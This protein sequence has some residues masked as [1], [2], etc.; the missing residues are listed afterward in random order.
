MTNVLLHRSRAFKRLAGSN[1]DILTFDGDTDYGVVR[2]TLEARGDLDPGIQIRNMWEEL[3]AASDSALGKKLFQVRHRNKHFAPLG[4]G[5]G[6][7]SLKRTRLADDGETVRQVDYF[8][9]D[10]SLLV[11]DRRDVPGKHKRNVTL[12]DHAGKPLH[13]WTRVS[14]LYYFWLDKVIG[15]DVAYLTIDSKTVA[16]F[17]YQYRRDNAATI[18]LLHNSHLTA[19]EPAPYGRLTASRLAG[20]QHLDEF[21]AVA[22]LTSAQHRDLTGLLGDGGNLHVI[23]NSRSLPDVEESDGGRE[24]TKGVVVARLSSTKRLNH[25]I[26]VIANLEQD[27]RLDIYGSGS[28][29]ASLQ[30]LINKL[31]VQ[32]SVKL[33]GH[34]DG[35]AEAF[36]SASFTM[37]TSKFEG[38]GLTLVEAMAVGCIP[39]AYDVKYGPSDIIEDGVSGFV[40]D[41]G[42]AAAMTEALKSFLAKPEHEVAAMREAARRRARLFADDEVVRRWGGMFTQLEGQKQ[43]VRGFDVRIKSADIRSTANGELVVEVE[44]ASSRSLEAPIAHICFLGRASDVAIRELTEAEPVSSGRTAATYKAVIAAEKYQWPE[45]GILDLFL[46]IRDSSGFART[47]ITASKSNTGKQLAENVSSYATKYGNLSLRFRA[48]AD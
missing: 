9:A 28:R 14:D 17:M 15:D 1:V 8:R 31:G 45:T 39:F 47:R 36:Q 20:L 43:P 37:L 6:D 35:A 4:K 12:C 41:F 29:H 2:R 44:A 19:G 34:R 30:S 16:N 38:F 40:I 42:D 48:D 46:D 22:T 26:Q 24:R 25:A 33:W 13:S 10:G 27:L 32:D 23:P 7:N 11:S 18:Y 21:D 5:T 3:R